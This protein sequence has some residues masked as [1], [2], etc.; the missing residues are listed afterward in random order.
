[1]TTLD[2]ADIRT[3]ALRVPRRRGALGGL[4]LMVLGAWAAL[5]PFVGPYL[6]FAFTPDKAWTWTS[7]RG[8]LEVLPGCVIGV[9]GLVLLLTTNRLFAVTATWYAIAGGAWLIVGPQLIHVVD[10][11]SP[12]NPTGSSNGMQAAEWIVY[13]YGLGALVLVVAST[14]HGRLSMRS[15]G[16]VQAARA[17]AMETAPEVPVTR[18]APQP[19]TTAAPAATTMAPEQ[20]GASRWHF[21]PARRGTTPDTTTAAATPD[22]ETTAGATAGPVRRT[23]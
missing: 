14:L 20:R 7:A 21:P 12:G 9:A 19:V 16:D 4:F 15:L 17:L 2:T 1:M 13:F 5:V 10:T 6:D 22:E 11:G 8:W 3:A 18:A 23:M